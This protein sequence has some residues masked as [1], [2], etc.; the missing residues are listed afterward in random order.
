MNW[1]RSIR[2]TWTLALLAIPAQAQARPTIL[3]E[4]H[5]GARPGAAGGYMALLA[6]S[7]G[8]RGL[9]VGEALR[10][11]VEA[12]RWFPAGPATEPAGVRALVK[13]GR[14]QFIKGDH[15]RAIATLEKARRSLL[16]STRVM[17]ADQSLRRSLHGTLLILAHAYLRRKETRLATEHIEEVIRSFPDRELSLVKHGPDLA[18]FYKKVR[19][20]LRRTSRGA[21]SVITSSEGCL[22]FV[23]ERFVGMSPVRV[24]ELYPG[25]YRVHVQRP[26]RPGRV[27]VITMSGKDIELQVDLPF[28]SALVTRPR[29][30]FRFDSPGALKRWESSYA[31]SLARALGARSVIV[32]GTRGRTGVHTLAGSLVSA[33]TGKTVRSASVALKASTPSLQRIEALGRFLVDGEASPKLGDVFPAHLAR[34]VLRPASGPSTAVDSRS[35]FAAPPAD[36]DPLDVRSSPLGVVKWVAL[37]VSVAV[38]AGGI[39]L[40]AMDGQAVPCDLPEGVLCPERYTSKTPGAILIAAGG[41]V[42]AAA[43]FL[44]YVD[45]RRTSSAATASVVSPWVSRRGGGI[46]AAVSF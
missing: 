27:H 42:A 36:H 34:R 23:N 3:L 4:S 46:T 35:A 13:D 28:H 14:R 20:Q 30:G 39:T 1:R 9:L 5:A 25:R 38:L 41:S 8:S 18:A 17:A 43:G 45:H 2:V 33:A 22:V 10:Q 32:V 40:L 29:V 6:R 31:A 44:F 37:G 12:E 21:L 19:Q 16:A 11:R 26:Q 15:A 7:L 24:P